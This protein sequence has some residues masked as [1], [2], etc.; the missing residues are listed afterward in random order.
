[1]VKLMIKARIKSLRSE[2]TS[3]FLKNKSGTFDIEAK[4][5]FSEIYSNQWATFGKLNWQLAGHFF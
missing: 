1:M 3:T 4:R 5:S 2:T